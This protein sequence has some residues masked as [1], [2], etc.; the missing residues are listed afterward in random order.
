MSDLI[1]VDAMVTGARRALLK[2]KHARVV[3][4]DL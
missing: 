4:K 1:F 2:R 3:Q